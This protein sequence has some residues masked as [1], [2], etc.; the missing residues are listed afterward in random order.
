MIEID[1]QKDSAL[2]LYCCQMTATLP[3]ITVTRYKKSRDDF[4]YEMQRAINDIVDELVEQ[5]ME[6]AD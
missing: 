3:P 2:G 4:R 1:I 5:A 6:D